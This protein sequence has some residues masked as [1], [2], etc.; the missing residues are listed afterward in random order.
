MKKTQLKNTEIKTRDGLI[1]YKNLI[2]TCLNNPPKGG[3][4]LKTMRDRSKVLEK[5]E[6][7]NKE[8]E[9]EDAEYNTLKGCVEAMRW[10]SMHKDILQFCEDIIK[11]KE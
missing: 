8:L 6:K 7:A 1:S 3:F 10:N 9:L 11:K 4:D 5:L 2:E